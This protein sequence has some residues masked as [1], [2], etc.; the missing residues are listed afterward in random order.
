MATHAHS[1]PVRAVQR[2][3]SHRQRRKVIETTL[4]RLLAAVEAA[5]ADLDQ[6]DGDADFEPN[7]GFT[8]RSLRYYGL[9][10]QEYLT[11][12]AG[13]DR[14]E[15]CEDEGAQ[16]EDE[17]AE[18]GDREPDAPDA[19]NWQEEGDQTRLIPGPAYTHVTAR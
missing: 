10:S 12:G 11:G 2:A 19:C 7:L 13:D 3:P 4:D 17:G 18:T 14:E 16:C 5:V 15:V 8:E 9:N 1:T 6:L